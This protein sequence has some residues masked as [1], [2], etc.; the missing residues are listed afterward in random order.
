MRVEFAVK[1]VEHQKESRVIEDGTHRPDEDHEA[2]D[3]LDIPLARGLEIFLVDMIRRN[4]NLRCIVKEVVQ[5]NLNRRHGQERQEV[6]SADHAEHVPEVRAGAHADVFDDVAEHLSSLDDAVLKHEE[7]F[8]QK[9]DVGGFLGDVDRGVDGNA[10]IRRAHRRSVVDAVAHVAHDMA[11]LLQG[12]DDALL[13]RRR[14]TGKDIVLLRQFAQLRF[15]QA[16]KLVAGDDLFSSKPT[17]LQ[18]FRVTSALSPVRIL[19]VTPNRLSEAR[20]LAAEPLGGSRKA[21]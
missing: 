6:A 2:P 17:S 20:A 11:A 5:Q 10:H 13:L 14:E 7:T 3:V 4:A 1:E 19:V 12:G 9:N 21:M 18:I 16:K 8:F 15:I